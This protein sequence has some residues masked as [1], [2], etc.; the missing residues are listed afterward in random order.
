MCQ[1]KGRATFNVKAENAL[2]VLLASSIW[3]LDGRFAMTVPLSFDPMMERIRLLENS[4]WPTFPAI[5][6]PPLGEGGEP[7]LMWRRTESLPSENG[8]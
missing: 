2:A 7:S 8:Y 1:K 4:A 6:I 3:L 5:T